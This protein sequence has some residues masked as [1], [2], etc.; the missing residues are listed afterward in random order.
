IRG[1]S[2]IH[3]RPPAVAIIGVDP[4]ADISLTDQQWRQGRD[5]RRQRTRPG[6]SI[7][8]ERGYRLHQ[9]D[10]PTA[11]HAARAVKA[12]FIKDK[13]DARRAVI[14][15]PGRIGEAA[16]ARRGITIQCE[17]HFDFCPVTLREGHRYLGF[18]AAI[19]TRPSEPKINLID[20]PERD[21]PAVRLRV[22]VCQTFIRTFSG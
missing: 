10:L 12:A 17:R 19:R 7:G 20:G 1:E 13:K 16:L 18:P 21:G 14:N 6:A 5:V 8:P 2:K 4:Y 11:P 15:I 22:L 3:I 9:L